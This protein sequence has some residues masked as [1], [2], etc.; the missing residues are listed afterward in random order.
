M[1][2]HKKSN[3]TDSCAIQKSPVAA[4]AQNEAATTSIV[5]ATQIS[6][7]ARMAKLEENF[8]I[9]VNA[10]KNQLQPE[11]PQA[12]PE[13]AA[14]QAGLLQTILSLAQPPAQPNIMEQL[15]VE[16][17]RSNLQLNQ[18]ITKSIVDKAFKI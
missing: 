4:D 18:A 10:L 17:L 1:T 5:D 7:E 9:L 14:N 13:A 11:Q 6:L 8:N 12:Q 15:T 3:D 16:M 2:T